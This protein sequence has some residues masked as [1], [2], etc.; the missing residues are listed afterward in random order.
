LQGK[1]VV[2]RG[3]L[4]EHDGELRMQIRHPTALEWVQ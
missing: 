4:Y 2:A 1:Q 3:W